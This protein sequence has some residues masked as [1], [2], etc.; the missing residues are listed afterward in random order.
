L[1]ALAVLPEGLRFNSQHPH[2]SSQSQ[3]QGA[4]H[5]HTDTSEAKKL[6]YV[7][8]T[9]YKLEYVNKTKSFKNF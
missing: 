6:E 8:K 2:G 9:E 5:P 4:Q 7:N 3:F 1:R